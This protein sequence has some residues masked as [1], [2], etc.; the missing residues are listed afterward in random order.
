MYKIIFI[1]LISFGLFFVACEEKI[2]EQDTELFSHQA[3]SSC[4]GCHIDKNLLA[5]VADSLENDGG[6]SG[7]G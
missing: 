4:V 2:I 1:I 6:E 7:E 3:N 5:V